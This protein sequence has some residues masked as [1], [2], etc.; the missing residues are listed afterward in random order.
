MDGLDGG[1]RV[2]DMS[3]CVRCGGLL[4]FESVHP[5]RQRKA[6]AAEEFKAMS[7]DCVIR[8]LEEFVDG[9]SN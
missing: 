3:L 1:P 9:Q 4:V 6:T 5:F 2:G 8:A 7:A